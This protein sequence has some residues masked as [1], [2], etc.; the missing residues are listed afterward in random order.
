MRMIIR[1]GVL[2]WG[3]GRGAV[4]DIERER[5][6]QR[7]GMRMIIRKCVWVW[8]WGIGKEID[9]DIKRER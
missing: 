9:G 1:K 2:V 8:V 5:E 7:K 6:T 3:S 4:E